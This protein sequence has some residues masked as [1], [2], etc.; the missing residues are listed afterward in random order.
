MISGSL[1]TT[2]I[3]D[4]IKSI[5]DKGSWPSPEWRRAPAVFARDA[6]RRDPSIVSS[7]LTDPTFL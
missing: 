3:A 6:C 1:N 5:E 4:G 7:N 2:L